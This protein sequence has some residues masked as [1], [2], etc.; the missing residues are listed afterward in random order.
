MASKTQA[1]SITL[2]L[3]LLLLSQYFSTS[4]GSTYHYV[5]YWGQ[6]FTE[7][8]GE[9]DAACDTNRY[10]IINIG[11]L[12]VFGNHQAPEINL[13]GHCEEYSEDNP[14]SKYAS[15]I[16][17]C[18][19]L[20]IKIFL[21]LGGPSGSYT[22]SSIADAQELS[23]YLWTNFL[24]GEPGSEGPLGDVTLDGI[25]FAIESG[26]NVYYDTLVEFLNPHRTSEGARYFYLSAAP[27]CEFPD[28]YLNMAIHT[29]MFDYIWIRFYNKAS[30]EYSD[31]DAHNLLEAWDVWITQT[32]DKSHAFFVGLPACEGEEGY[33]P[34]AD[35]KRKV[36]PKV[37]SS[38]FFGGFMLWEDL[39]CKYSDKLEAHDHLKAPIAIENLKQSA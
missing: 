37:K 33:I 4:H 3:P 29:W 5:T 2:L 28:D 38:A 22:L 9:L 21:S 23:D 17:H 35:L 13:P 31:G 16:A 12:D 36:I 26:G 1:S 11:F 8:E 24:S 7:G 20:G 19:S 18:Q 6:N 27:H 39:V 34:I 14:C 30:C 32:V 10:E 15:Q 25:D